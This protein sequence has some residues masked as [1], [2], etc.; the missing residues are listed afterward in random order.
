M[1]AIVT[2]P[3]ALPLD[4][5]VEL[6]VLTVD[7]DGPRA[8]DA[9]RMRACAPWKF[10]AD[11]ARVCVGDD[12]RTLE[13]DVDGRLVAS[14]A[15]LAAAFPAPPGV[16]APADPWRAALAEGLQLRVP[17]IAE[18]DVDGHTLVA[19][20]DLDVVEAT[21]TRQNPRLVELEFDGTS[22]RTL[23]AGRRYHFYSPTGELAN[24]AA[25]LD[26]PEA[27]VPATTPVAYTAGTV[28]GSTWVFAV[29]TDETGG[30]SAIAVPLTIE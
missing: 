14:A 1:L 15:A 8:V 9:V 16:P 30:M 13:L 2:E 10:I 26:D 7:P 12:A 3:S 25:Q 4:G 21:T 20:R 29:A 18:V 11:P 24:P 23:R 5:A 27:L 17:I 6:S 28:V 19:R 22:T